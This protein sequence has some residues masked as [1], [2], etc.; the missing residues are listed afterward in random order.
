VTTQSLRAALDAIPEPE[1]RD[2]LDREIAAS[3]AYLESEVARTR[4]AADVYW[5][6][7][8]GPWW[9]ML[10]LFELGE[11]ARI[12]RA[13]VEA[14]TARLDALP[15]KFFPI[16]PELEAPGARLWCDLA[17]HCA[18]GSMYQVLTACGVD[19]DRALPWIRPWFVRYQMRDGGLNCDEEAY[20]VEHECPSSMVGT[21][22]PF[23]A[24][25]VA[26]PGADR[27]AFL[28][29]AAQ[30]LIERQLTRGSATQFNA[31]ERERAPAWL[32]PCEPRFYYYD[33]LRGLAALV[34]WADSEHG[35]VPRAAL[36][37][38]IEHLTTTFPDGVIHAQ[39]HGFAVCPE[40][41]AQAPDGEWR[42]VPTT[43]FALLDAMSALGRPSASLTRQ[44]T[45]TR[46]RLRALLDA[47]RIT[48]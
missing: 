2:S 1:I 13:M 12:P 4:L 23:E 9:H 45:E 3:V 32:Q 24:M 36:A 7:W 31:V 6:K 26:P 33:V 40:G 21:I 28:D 35:S 15:L 42:R 47:G 41:W 46:R 44:W 27:D 5:P 29:R 43:R 17:C 16:R 14:M 22:A 48:A 10:A 30:F 18:L 34:R 25:L 20:L 38:A 11:A 8:D 19:V 37:G 39:R